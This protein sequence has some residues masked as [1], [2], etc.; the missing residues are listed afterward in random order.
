MLAALPQARYG[1]A[2][3]AGCG[4][5][6]MTVALA[7]RC[8]TVLAA[9]LSAAALRLTDERLR[10]AGQRA[11]VTLERHHL[12]RD[13]PGNAV[14]AFDLIVLSEIAY[15]LDAEELATLVTQCNATLAPGGTLMLCHWRAPFQ[16]RRLST[17]LVHTAFHA[18]PGL[19]RLLRHEEADFLLEAW[20]DEGWSV[21]QREGLG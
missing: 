11:Q 20:S 5:G 8:D 18:S 6:E 13:W 10:D 9:D 14:P 12:P 1:H 17:E 2:Y 16:D 15:Y 21:A 19:H 3:E 7:M 4:N